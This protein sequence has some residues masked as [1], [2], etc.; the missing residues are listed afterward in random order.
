MFCDG[1]HSNFTPSLCN[2]YLRSHWVRKMYRLPW[3]GKLVQVVQPSIRE[4]PRVV[5]VPTVAPLSRRALPLRWQPADPEVEAYNRAHFS[6]DH[7]RI[8]FNTTSGHRVV[9]IIPPR[10][11]GKFPSLFHNVCIVFTYSY[12]AYYLPIL[13]LTGGGRRRGRVEQWARRHTTPLHSNISSK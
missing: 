10:S 5:V 7:H 6:L 1:C 2:A 8:V 12:D 4:L 9:Q 13:L 3:R 11:W